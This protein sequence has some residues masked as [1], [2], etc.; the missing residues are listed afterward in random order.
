MDLPWYA[1]VTSPSELDG[2]ARTFRTYARRASS[3]LG[4]DLDSLIT[5]APPLPPPPPARPSVCFNRNFRRISDCSC[6]PTCRTC[7]FNDLL[8]G[9]NGTDTATYTGAAAAVSLL[10]AGGQNTG[11]AGTD[12]LSSIENLTGGAG[13]DTLR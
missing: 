5:T 13:N 9:G 3:E 8:A 10:I 4:I 1:S 12:T 2:Y 6:H 11:G 7:G